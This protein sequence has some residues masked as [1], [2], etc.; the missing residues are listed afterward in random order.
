MNC[1]VFKDMLASGTPAAGEVY[2]GSDVVRL[3]D[4]PE[5]VRLFV[6]P[7]Y[8]RRCVCVHDI[9]YSVSLIATG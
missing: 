9:M 1:R 5:D 3:S 4:D 6:T 2:E 7:V 8:Y